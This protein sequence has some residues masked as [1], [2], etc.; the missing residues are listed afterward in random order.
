L[1]VA[2]SIFS[3]SSN[4]VIAFFATSVIVAS[5]FDPILTPVRFPRYS[6]LADS[7]RSVSGNARRSPPVISSRS[8]PSVSSALFVKR[9]GYKQAPF[10]GAGRILGIRPPCAPRSPADGGAKWGRRETQENGEE[11]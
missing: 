6:I 10:E 4:D 2:D 11:C 3:G 5:S 9:A 7:H 1:S 8:V